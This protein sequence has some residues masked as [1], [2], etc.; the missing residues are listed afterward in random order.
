MIK[1]LVCVLYQFLF[2]L[3]EFFEDSYGYGTGYWGT[4]E[5]GYWGWNDYKGV[6]G[7]RYVT[8]YGDGYDYVN[9][10]FALGKGFDDCAAHEG[11][12]KIKEVTYVRE[13]YS[14]LKL[15]PL[16]TYTCNCDYFGHCGNINLM[17]YS[18]IE[19][20][21]FQTHNGT[22]TFV[23]YFLGW[24]FSIIIHGILMKKQLGYNVCSVTVKLL[25]MVFWVWN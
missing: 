8:G 5:G 14:A 20:K 11:A 25:S 2:F 1:Q 16:R 9:H 18:G 6:Y 15:R 24:K 4:D 23:S 17:I 13:G 7:G 3:C 22:I 10:T 21:L 19:N 12:L